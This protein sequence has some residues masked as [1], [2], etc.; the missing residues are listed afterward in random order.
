MKMDTVKNK[1]I[2]PNCESEIIVYT[3]AFTGCGSTFCQVCHKYIQIDPE[4]KPELW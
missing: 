4:H 1:V 3:N 2:C